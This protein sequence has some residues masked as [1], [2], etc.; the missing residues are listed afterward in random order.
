M[1][2]GNPKFVGDSSQVQA[3]LRNVQHI[4][5]SADGAFAAI[6]KSGDVVSWG[7][8]HSG[9]DSSQVQEHARAAE[10]RPANPS[11]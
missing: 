10:K 9:G 6:L 1:T 5:A 11:N 8:P 4:Q 2:W 7:H 3:Q